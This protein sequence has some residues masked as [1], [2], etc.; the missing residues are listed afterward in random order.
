[1]SADTATNFDFKNH[2][3]ECVPFLEKLKEISLSA[4]KIEYHHFAAHL[5]KT[6]PI[7]Y[8]YPLPPCVAVTDDIDLIYD[9]FAALKEKLKEW[10]LE[11]IGEKAKEENWEKF[12]SIFSIEEELTIDIIHLLRKV[13]Y[14][15]AL[16]EALSEES[17]QRP[18]GEVEE[19]SSCVRSREV[20]KH[21]AFTLSE[22]FLKFVDKI[23]WYIIPHACHTWNRTFGLELARLVRPNVSWK[24]HTYEEEPG[25]PESEHTTVISED[26]KLMFDILKFWQTF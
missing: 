7:D 3:Q 8:P 12:T 14:E 2:W 26:G 24:S 25:F 19:K 5:F 6:K 17:A 20:E 18:S 11:E 23:E 22:Y 16:S 1:M 15:D 13:G 10:G 9:K 21:S 4:S